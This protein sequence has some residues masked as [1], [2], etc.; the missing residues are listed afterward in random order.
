MDR[1]LDRQGRLGSAVNGRA[2]VY[3]VIGSGKGPTMLDP[4]GPSVGS[5]ESLLGRLGNLQGGSFSS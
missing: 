3:T 2:Q 5:V 1:P 4:S